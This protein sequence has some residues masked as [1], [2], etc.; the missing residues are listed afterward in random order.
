MRG[1]YGSRMV[2]RQHAAADPCRL[3][4]DRG[5]DRLMV[6]AELSCDG[7][8]LPPL[9][10]VQAQ[11]LGALRGRDHR[12]SSCSARRGAP[13]SEPATGWS[14]RRPRIAWERAVEPRRHQGRRVCSIAVQRW[15]ID[16]SRGS[17]RGRRAAGRDGRDDPRDC[18]GA[19][20]WRPVATGAARPRGSAAC[21]R[22]GRGRTPRRWRTGGC[23]VGRSSGVAAGPRRRSARV[24]LRLD[25][26][27]PA[28]A[29][30]R[31]PAR[32]VGARGGHEGPALIPGPHPTL[33]VRFNA[34]RLQCEPHQPKGRPG[35]PA[36]R[37]A[38]RPTIRPAV[39]T[40]STA[41]VW[42]TERR[43]RARPSVNAHPD[44]VPARESAAYRRAWRNYRRRSSP[45]L[46]RAP[47]E[48]SA[49]LEWSLDGTPFRFV[50]VDHTVRP[51]PGRSVSRGYPG[52][53]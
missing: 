25:S 1:R 22:R 18:A 3:A 44:V 11:D 40:V 9:A 29:Q 49:A 5:A 33:E 16:P 13:A 24:K 19:A 28:V 45:R 10:E 23:S 30:Q 8:D 15:K 27:A 48:P 52:R 37:H 26:A 38:R 35:L 39:V 51:S 20:P 6:E 50:V 31:R 46:P 14:A 36:V 42:W 17:G 21:S 43:I 47:D 53:A 4:F 7:P 2:R 34:T 32:S 12:P 41:G